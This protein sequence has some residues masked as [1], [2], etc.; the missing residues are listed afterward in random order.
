[1]LGQTGV[2]YDFIFI[3][4]IMPGLS[5]EALIRAIRALAF[6]K[7]PLLV[8]VSAHDINQI[9]ELCQQHYVEYFL[10]KPVLPKDL[11]QFLRQSG[12]RDS[13]VSQPPLTGRQ[14]LE[15]MRILVVEDNPINQLIASEILSQYGALVDCA[16]NGKE[17]VDK[18][19]ASFADKPYHAVL[20]DIQMPVMDGYEATRIVRDQFRDRNLPIIALTANAML[21]EKE[22]CLT[23]GM[24]AH[25][26]KP[27]Q[28]E[29]LLQTLVSF[30]N[31]PILQ[32]DPSLH[33]T[34]T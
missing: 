7:P 32:P 14:P 9:H 20:M 21:E 10:P 3:D 33:L 24:N 17:G 5:G 31:R 11:E 6:S 23:V 2:D 15:S 13:P 12:L 8:I 4:W 18:I 16:D 30:R 25:I 22:H 34:A 28:P 29:D 26:T 19:T 1:M 27:F